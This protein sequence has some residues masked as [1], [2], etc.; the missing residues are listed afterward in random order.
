[1]VHAR[2]SWVAQIGEIA[3]RSSSSGLQTRLQD[4]NIGSFVRKTW[5]VCLFQSML[6]QQLF[7]L[8]VSTPVSSETRY[9]K[10]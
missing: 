6:A 3:V 1:M 4:F 9:E 7:R 5:H 2:V 10:E 8:G